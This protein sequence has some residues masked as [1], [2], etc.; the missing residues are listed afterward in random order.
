MK[1]LVAAGA[2]GSDQDPTR[3][4]LVEERLR[5]T[6]RS[7]R[8]QDAVKRSGGR[9][10]LGAIANDELDVLVAQSIESK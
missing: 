1:L 4:Q 6:R 10:A 5:D 9:M 7:G 8:N 2:D 3:H